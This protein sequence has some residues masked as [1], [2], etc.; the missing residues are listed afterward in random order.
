MQQTNSIKRPDQIKLAEFKH[1]SLQIAGK[2]NFLDTM[3][4]DKWDD[5]LIIFQ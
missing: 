4:N 2:M 3:I 5:S 1:D